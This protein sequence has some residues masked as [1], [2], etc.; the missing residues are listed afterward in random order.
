[1]EIARDA[2]Q[3]KADFCLATGVSPS[4]YDQLTQYEINA[5]IR[6]ANKR[7]G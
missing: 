2:A 4:E 6:Q 1:M 5:F 3:A 7:K